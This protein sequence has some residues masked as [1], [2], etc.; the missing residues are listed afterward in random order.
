[1]VEACGRYEALY[2]QMGAWR[3]F[4][5]L[6]MAG[7]ALSSCGTTTTIQV[8]DVETKIES[9]LVAE[10]E[11]ETAV[12]CGDRSTVPAEKGYSFTCDATDDDG[13]FPSWR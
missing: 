11:V 3:F 9:W 7:L 13:P 6:M 4:A 12:N 5:V 1:M 10:F 8:E 2:V